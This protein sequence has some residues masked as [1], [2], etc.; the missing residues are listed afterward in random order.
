MAVEKIINIRNEWSALAAKGHVGG[1]EVGDRRD[2]GARSDA[3]PFADLQS[4]G[5]GPAEVGGRLPLMKNRLAVR[6]KEGNALRGDAESTA[7][8]ESGLGENFSETE[9]QP[10][11]GAGRDGL[12]IRDAKNFFAQLERKA[13]GS[14]AEQLGVQLRRRARDASEG[15]I[16][17]IGGRAGHEAEDRHGLG[18]HKWRKG[19]LTQRGQRT[20]RTP[21]QREIKSVQELGASLA[22]LAIA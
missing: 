10:A 20:Q 9:I 15:D 13:E 11:Q 14:V 8:G 5:G 19:F 16:Y 18:G 22:S 7:G 3:G 6:A 17:A 12:L 1:A 2:T 21:S 4:T